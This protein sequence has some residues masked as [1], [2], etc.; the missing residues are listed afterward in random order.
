MCH[1][2]ASNNGIDSDNHMRTGRGPPDVKT[3]TYRYY[4]MYTLLL[5]SLYRLVC[6]YELSQAKLNHTDWL[7]EAFY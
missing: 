5:A 6:A 1:I 2:L 4:V 3:G 7:F